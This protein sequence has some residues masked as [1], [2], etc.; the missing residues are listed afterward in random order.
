[1]DTPITGNNLYAAVIAPVPFLPAAL[2]NTN[3]YVAGTTSPLNGNLN[4]NLY[5]S[6]GS[7]GFITTTMQSAA[8]ANGNGTVLN[9]TGMVGAT[10]TVNCSVACTGGTAVNFE[11]TQDGVNY[12]PIT[13]AQIGTIPPVFVTS[14]VNQTTTPLL[15]EMPVANFVNIRARISAYSAGTVTV[16]GTTTPVPYNGKEIEASSNVTSVGGSAT[17]LTSNGVTGSG[18]QRV[19]ISSDST[20][21]VLLA[22]A[23]PAGTTPITASATG[24]TAATTATLAASASLKTYLCSYSVRANA[25]AATTVLNT[26]TGVVTA[27]LSHQMWVAPAASG[28]GIDEQVF[29]PCVPSSAINTAVAVVSGAPGT[30]GLVSVTAT[31]YQGP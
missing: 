8:V 20:G 7:A 25:T 6:Q 23:Y 24:T 22:N 2:F 10:L 3:T 4:G 18:T 29:W 21:Q 14:S 11:G 12:T 30:G 16:T 5:V 19:T 9:T 15:F 17:G 28:I 1:V 26:V 13:V 27:T 31:G